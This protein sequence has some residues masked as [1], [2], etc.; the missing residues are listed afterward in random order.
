M[1]FTVIYAI[2]FAS[3]IGFLL[4]WKLSQLLTI[5]ARAHI[6]S[7]YSKWFLYTIIHPRFNGSSDI[8]IMAGSII[9]LFV[10][11]NIVVCRLGVQSL[12]DL[13]ARLARVCGT[14]L[15][16]LYFGGRSNLV[17][18]RIFR[19]SDTEYHL[20]HRWIGRI[21]I[22]EGLTHGT[23]CVIKTKAATRVADLSVSTI[24]SLH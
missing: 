2:S 4:A 6:L 7:L 3:A 14:N 1:H 5:H 18:G 11:A 15:V 23:L 17:A 12:S 22:I 24:N 9:I 21:T 8:T 16:A 20:L 13:S 10:V 19:I